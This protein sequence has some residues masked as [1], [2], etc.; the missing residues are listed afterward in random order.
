M[1]NLK[2]VIRKGQT[3][4]SGECV[5]YIQITHRGSEEWISTGIF[6]SAIDEYNSNPADLVITNYTFF[7]I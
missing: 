1:A 3:K 7:I 2:L 5:I 4:E 6:N